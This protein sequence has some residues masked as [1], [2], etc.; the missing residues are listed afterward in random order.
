MSERKKIATISVVT[1]SEN[2]YDHI[3]D[4]DGGF[5]DD[6]LR[7]HIESHGHKGLC[8]QLAYMQWQV[9]DMMRTINSETGQTGY[10]S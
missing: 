4:V 3:G 2:E 7:Y 1:D 6:Q 5:S 10:M 9:Y 8:E